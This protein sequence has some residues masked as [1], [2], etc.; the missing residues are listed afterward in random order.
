MNDDRDA[1]ST[2]V[3]AVMVMM[4]LSTLAL[5]GLARTLSAMA[6]VRH[7]QDYDTAL[8]V[9]D[10]GLNDALY[11]LDNGMPSEAGWTKEGDAG[12]GHW[13]YK[14]TRVAATDYEV[15]VVGSVGTSSHG[16]RARITRGPGYALFTQDALH[17][18]GS[19][20]SGWL[21]LNPSSW[22]TLGDPDSDQVHVGSNTSI[23]VGPGADAG[24]FQHTHLAATCT[25]C[26]HNVHH[27][28]SYPM[29]EPTAPSGA[30]QA[31]PALGTFTGIVNGQ[32]GVP[33]VCRRDVALAG[34]ITVVN[35]PF[36]LDVLPST[37]ASG[38]E[39]HHSIDMRTAVVNAGGRA[40]MVQ[41]NKA[42][43]APLLLDTASSAA[44]VS[45][46]GVLYAPQTA[47]RIQS[48]RW[49]T[50]S[51]VVKRVEVTG[52]PILK[53][54]YDLDVQ[55]LVNDWAVTNYAEIPAAEADVA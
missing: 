20:T 38:N 33:F 52:A 21:G 47:L 46:S 53:L 1:G 51:I 37:D 9:A 31:C 39:V 45:F 29:A 14:T 43:P 13:R 36:V 15:E 34:A 30:T 5:G 40:G 35:G 42:G 55:R 27:P 22:V 6:L 48:S 25:G 23:T 16:V 24:D 28:R 49:W 18:G 11:L 2:L 54:G 4:V 50:G 10:A 12:A 32:A 8:A 19:G 17:I 44:S 7:G 3:I 41:I 26:A